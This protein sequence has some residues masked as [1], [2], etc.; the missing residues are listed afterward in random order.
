[1]DDFSK[2]QAIHE[3]KLILELYQQHRNHTEIAICIQRERKIFKQGNTNLTHCL[4]FVEQTILDNQH[5][6]NHDECGETD[7]E[8]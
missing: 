5:R 7:A 4:T 6:R 1:M 3:K 8:K 2:E